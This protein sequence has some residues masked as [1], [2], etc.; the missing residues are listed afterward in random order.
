V[1]VVGLQKLQKELNLAGLANFVKGAVESI[2]PELPVDEQA[3]L[4]PY[5]QTWEFPREKLILGMEVPNEEYRKKICYI[6]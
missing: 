4:L 1:S 3:D 5:D 6:R 2:N